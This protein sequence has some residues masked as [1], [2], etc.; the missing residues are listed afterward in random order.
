MGI[1]TLIAL[2]ADFATFT[3]LGKEVSDH[4][5]ENKF[6]PPS[7]DFSNIPDDLEYCADK[8]DRY[9]T[10]K[11]HSVVAS[12]VITD[13]ERSAVKKEFY[14]RNQNLL[15]MRNDTDRYIDSYLDQLNELLYRRMSF[16]EKFIKKQ[17]EGLEGHISDRFDSQKKDYRKGFE[18]T[19]AIIT[20][21]KNE[22]LDVLNNKNS[23][24]KAKKEL[25][26]SKNR[27]KYN[28]NSTIFRGRDAEIKVLLRNR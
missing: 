21:A 2:L 27:F 17:I 24:N 16:G 12:S 13:E 8:V 1:L 23:D 4:I 26:T 3:S 22:I 5:K 25:P 9:L 19:N 6:S 28:S 11:Y 7:I 10:S 15:S 20:Q 18:D 14:K